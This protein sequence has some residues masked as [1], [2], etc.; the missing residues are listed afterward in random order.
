MVWKDVLIV[1]HWSKWL[2]GQYSCEE[3]TRVVVLYMHFVGI[4]TCFNNWWPPW[5]IWWINK[6]SFT[7][8]WQLKELN[9][10]FPVRFVTLPWIQFCFLHLVKNAVWDPLSVEINCLYLPSFLNVSIRNKGLITIIIEFRKTQRT[11]KWLQHSNQAEPLSEERQTLQN[12]KVTNSWFA[13]YISSPF[14]D[15]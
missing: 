8:L 11:D 4:I 3:K 9:S 2:F 15:S 1:S 7:Y 6:I 14:L 5:Y 13:D 10:S 12:D